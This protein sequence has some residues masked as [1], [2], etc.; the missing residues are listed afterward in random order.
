MFW[1]RTGDDTFIQNG[2]KYIV[3]NNANLDTYACREKICNLL[4]HIAPDIVAELDM[5]TYT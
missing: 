1:K 4:N 2:I 5:D 3:S